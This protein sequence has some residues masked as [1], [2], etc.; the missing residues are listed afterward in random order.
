MPEF[1]PPHP[2]S[3]EIDCSGFACGKPALDAFLKQRAHRNEGKYSRTYV[4]CA[5]REVAGYYTLSTGGVM[6][7]EVPARLRRNAPG[8]VPVILLARL[9]VDMRYQKRGLGAGLLK[10]ALQRA[11]NLSAIAGCRAVLVHALDAEAADFY[12]AFGFIAFP[13]AGMTYFLPV[14]TIGG[15][16]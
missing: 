6:R 16:L 10:D 4:V 8:I 13:D 14:E 7:G 11:L 3:A 12:R 15:V 1:T 5:G 2:I 9:A